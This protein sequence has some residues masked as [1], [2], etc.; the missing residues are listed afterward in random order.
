ML[1]DA[2]DKLAKSHKETAA[3][4]YL[5]THPATDARMRHLRSQ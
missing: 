5:S 4:G 2:L 3:A 1:A